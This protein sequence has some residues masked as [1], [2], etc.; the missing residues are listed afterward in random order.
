MLWLSLDLRPAWAVTLDLLSHYRVHCCCHTSYKRDRFA[1]C[2][3]PP[4]LTYH[5]FENYSSKVLQF[6]LLTAL[7]AVP[8][9]VPYSYQN[10]P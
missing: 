7:Q 6:I 1:G 2:S 9:A 5:L 4:L 8:H 3:T 10:I